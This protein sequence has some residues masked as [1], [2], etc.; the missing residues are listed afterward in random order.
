MIN[1]LKTKLDALGEVLD[2][3]PKNNKKNKNAFN[4][5]LKK[6]IDEYNENKIKVLNEINE[7][8]DEINKKR[9]KPNLYDIKSQINNLSNNL[10]LINEENTSYEKTGFDTLIYSLVH[11]Y[12]GNLDK[13]NEDILKLIGIFKSAGIELKE[14]DFYYTYYSYEYMKEYFKEDFNKGINT[15]R[16]KGIFEKIYWKCPSIITHIELS[17]RY[18]YN[19]YKKQFDL[20]Y[21]AL[22]KKFLYNE[23]TDSDGALSKLKELIIKRDDLIKTDTSTLLDDFIQNKYKISD[24]TDKSI[25]SFYKSF[26]NKDLLINEYLEYNNDLEKLGNT[27]KEYRTYKKFIYIIDYVKEIYS[28]KEKYLKTSSKLYKDILKKKK[29]LYKNNRKLDKFIRKNKEDKQEE[30]LNVINS[31]TNELAV[32]YKEYNINCVY[33]QL[34]NKIDNNSTIYDVL[35]LAYS[36]YLLLVECIKKSELYEEIDSKIIKDAYEELETYLMNPY[37]TFTN[38]TLA[39]VENDI[40]EIISD[41]YK[42]LDINITK[43]MISEG[44]LDNLINIID[45]LNRYKNI[46]NSTLTIEDIDFM[47]KSKSIIEK[48]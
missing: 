13:V 5:T 11:F 24:Y 46:K 41:I 14:T 4:E 8:I 9:V 15:E 3:M 35:Y 10:Y 45:N 47:C 30:M 29:L 27:L 12:K 42:L 7:R 34:V 37:N 23:S 38:T 32:M 44:D 17:F 20:Y 18:L 25:I 36:Y 2:S 21:L 31:I 16:M 6:Y 39:L 26:I 40:Q 48:E 28:E 33:E 19:K 1:E 22:E 43:E